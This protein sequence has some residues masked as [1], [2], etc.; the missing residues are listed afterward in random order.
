MSQ[1][2]PLII[3]PQLLEKY[4]T[5]SSCIILDLSKLENFQK[6]HIPNAIHLEYAKIIRNDKPVMGLLP[7]PAELSALLASLGVSD[8]THV[9]AY[10]DEGGGK[11]ARLLWTLDLM[12]FRAFSLLDGGIFSWEREGFPLTQEVKPATAGNFNATYTQDVVADKQYILSHLKDSNVKLLDAR[13]SDEYSGIKKF[14]EKG[15]H[16]PGAVNLDWVQTMNL[17]NNLRFKDAAELTKIFAALDITTDKEIIVY[18][19]THHRSSHTY[20]VLKSLGYQHIKGYAGA[21]SDWGND[22]NTPVEI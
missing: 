16:I 22:A 14:A 18:C 9:I 6:F 11:A 1:K 5:D 2:L 8:N 17:D 3:E 7:D 4:L 10:D 15:G 20:I 19:Q 21:W 12:G 13:S